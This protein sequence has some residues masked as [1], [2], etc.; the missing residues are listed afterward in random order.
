MCIRDRVS[1]PPPR[2]GADRPSLFA[3]AHR[4]STVALAALPFLVAFE[5]LAVSTVMPRAAEELGG[6]SLYPLVFAAP[7]ATS[8]VSIVVAGTWND[9]QGPMRV[10]TAGLVVFCAA[11]LM[12]GLAPSMS[13]LVAGR[14]LQGLGMGLVTVGLAGN[15]VGHWD[16]A[17]GVEEF[18]G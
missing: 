7:L 1:P 8:L 11:L 6:L 15:G 5:A 12:V 3:P 16:F 17:L 14:G 13:V 2:P 18:A 10:M 4:R 9:R